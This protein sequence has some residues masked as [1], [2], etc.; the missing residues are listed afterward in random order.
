MAVHAA[1][2]SRREAP[3]RISTSE[4]F[5][6][7]SQFRHAN[8]HSSRTKS[9]IAWIASGRGKPCIIKF[10]Q[11]HGSQTQELRFSD[12]SDEY[13]FGFRKVP[14]TVTEKG[15]NLGPVHVPDNFKLTGRI[16][17]EF[18]SLTYEFPSYGTSV[19]SRNSRRATRCFSA[20]SA[21]VAF[22]IAY[23]ACRGCRDL[24]TLPRCYCTTLFLQQF[25]T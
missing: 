3:L 17:N 2:E 7:G 15:C 6:T 8:C 21:L 25:Y 13:H 20:G 5:Q 10:Q 23:L 16:E 12:S 9:I 22:R 1:K 18:G 4:C 19:L 24:E 14:A 11:V